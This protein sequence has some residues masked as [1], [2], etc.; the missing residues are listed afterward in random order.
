M[1]VLL[2]ILSAFLSAC[3]AG[4]TRGDLPPAAVRQ[5]D[6]SEDPSIDSPANEGKAWLRFT[7]NL[8]EVDHWPF[9]LD[10]ISTKIACEPREQAEAGYWAVR[11]QDQPGDGGNNVT[12]ANDLAVRIRVSPEFELPFAPS[13]GVNQDYTVI[14]G[15]PL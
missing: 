9:G 13:R 15:E 5:S 14:S 10:D 1:L 12:I 4:I 7:H 2:V 11:Y 3:G 6:A 8:S